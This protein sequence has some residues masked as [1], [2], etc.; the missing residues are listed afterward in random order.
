MISLYAIRTESA[1]NRRKNTIWTKFSIF[2]DREVFQNRVSINVRIHKSNNLPQS[3]AG[4]GRRLKTHKFID[5]IAQST[6]RSINPHSNDCVI[7]L[8]IQI[9]PATCSIAPVLSS[10]VS[11]KNICK[12]SIFSPENV[13][14]VW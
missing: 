1:I 6:M 5:I 7:T 12:I 11:G 4:I 9:G 3:S 14:L 10:G 13:N 2:H 8:T